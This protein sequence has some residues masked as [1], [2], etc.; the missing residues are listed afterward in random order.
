VC[1]LNCFRDWGLA[2]DLDWGWSLGYSL[3]A[4]EKGS[5][6]LTLVASHDPS[7]QALELEP[8]IA[9]QSYFPSSPSASTSSQ[10]RNDT[11]NSVNLAANQEQEPQKYKAL[12]ALFQ[13]SESRSP[14]LLSLPSSPSPQQRAATWD[15]GEAKEL[16]T[17]LPRPQ[18]GSPVSEL[19]VANTPSEL[20]VMSPISELGGGDGSPLVRMNA[21]ETW[22][23]RGAVELSSEE[24]RVEMDSGVQGGGK[25][26]YYANAGAR[27]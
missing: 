4:Q 12:P 6:L 22:G 5:V 26:R 19:G 25:G 2:C 9:P 1:V 23:N 21:H 11:W 24:A 8:S 16:H 13:E 18:I 14:A 15:S 27:V 20:G 17:S 7:A 10:H 3:A